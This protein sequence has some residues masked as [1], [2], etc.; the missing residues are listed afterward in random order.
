MP[1]GPVY[2]CTKD[3][4]FAD[5]INLSGPTWIKLS[6][7]AEKLLQKLYFEG[8]SD[9]NDVYLHHYG[10]LANH[11]LAREHDQVVYLT[12]EGVEWAIYYGYRFKKDAWLEE[13]KAVRERELKELQLVL[14]VC[15][16]E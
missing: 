15:P 14:G 10:D 16:E 11:G 5:E 12:T 4:Y 8:P 3:R 6:P 1:V 13:K 2:P 9:S 7:D